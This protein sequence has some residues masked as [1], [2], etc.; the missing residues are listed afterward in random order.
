MAKMPVNTDA[1]QNELL[2]G[3]RADDGTLARH[4]SLLQ[5]AQRTMMD[6]TPPIRSTCTIAS[7]GTVPPQ[8]NPL[9]P[10][11]PNDADDAAMQPAGFAQ[12][13]IPMA[14]AAMQG[15]MSQNISRLADLP[16]GDEDGRTPGRRDQATTTTTK[17]IGFNAPGRE[18]HQVPQLVFPLRPGG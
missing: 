10:P 11:F 14:Q 7:Q 5:P 4:D 16:S 8:R 3:V 15:M 6:N 9:S 1:H 18:G 17:R 2:R 12:G 13:M